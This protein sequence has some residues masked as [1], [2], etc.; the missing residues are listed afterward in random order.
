MQEHKRPPRARLT[1]VDFDPLDFQ[2]RHVSPLRLESFKGE[3]GDQARKGEIF[4]S[5]EE[6]QVKFEAMVP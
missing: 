5:S 4:Y 3:L 1:V 6:A 2:K